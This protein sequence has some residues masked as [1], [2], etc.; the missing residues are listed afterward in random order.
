MA[1]ISERSWESIL[2]HNS[3]LNIEEEP[4]NQL[5]SCSVSRI[6]QMPRPRIQFPKLESLK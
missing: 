6:V 1:Y 5:L 2:V 4:E 3:P